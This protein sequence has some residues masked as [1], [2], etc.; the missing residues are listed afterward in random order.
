MRALVIPDVEVQGPEGL[1]LIKAQTAAGIAAALAR[2]PHVDA[3]R[4][5]LRDLIRQHP[6]FSAASLLAGEVHQTFGKADDAQKHFRDAIRFDPHN[7][8][9]YF[10]LSQVLK[11]NKEKAERELYAA[12]Y[13]SAAFPAQVPVIEGRAKVTEAAK[14]KAEV[15]DVRALAASVST[16]TFGSNYDSE[17]IPVKFT[18]EGSAAVTVNTATIGGKDAGAFRMQD[19]C[20]NRQLPPGGSC[21]VLVSYRRTGEQNQSAQLVVSSS[22]G[23]D[24]KVAL[25]AVQQRV[26]DR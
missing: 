21:E 17:G 18:N 4:R 2:K 12:A 1:D 20:S 15:R 7:V 19:G 5:R 8:L 9:A 26:Y 10:R 24:A 23:I 6:D 3:A 16:V 13:R 22:A 25:K 11:S 14:P